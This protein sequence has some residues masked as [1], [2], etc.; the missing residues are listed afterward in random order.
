MEVSVETG[1][2]TPLRGEMTVTRKTDLMEKVQ[3][4][5]FIA[6]A[7]AAGCTVAK[8][9]PDDGVDWVVTHRHGSHAPFRRV[10][11]E[12]QLKSTSQIPPP[13][14]EAFGFPLDRAT[15]DLLTEPSGW[16]RILIVS[17]LP[18]DIDDW[19]QA[20]QVGNV[21]QLRHLSYW[22]SLRG[23]SPTGNTQTTVPM[24]TSQVFD[25]LALCGIMQRV[26]RREDL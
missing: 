23:L 22:R 19:V 14:G 11:I 2:A 9:D 13:S 3:E 15:F 18:P 1:A 17:I 12:V 5:Q 25:D 26:G 7:A 24:L 6:S 10:S 21:F 16:P 20:D 4:A 8:P